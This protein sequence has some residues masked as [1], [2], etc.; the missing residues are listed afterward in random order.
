MAGTKSYEPTTLATTPKHQLALA[1]GDTS[2][3][4]GKYLWFDEEL[5]FFLD[6]NGGDVYLAA[7]DA[8][9]AAATSHAKIAV[10]MS[11]LGSAVN[12][13]R[14][15]V[16]REFRLMADAWA[17]RAAAPYSVRQA[18]EDGDTSWISTL[19]NR[20]RYEFEDNTTE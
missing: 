14:T 7:A 2:T 1:L 19:T 12:V 20:F 13:D 10:A 18:W 4:A 15:S 5:Q 11:V 9:R 6:E 3:E 8:C 16:A 17:A